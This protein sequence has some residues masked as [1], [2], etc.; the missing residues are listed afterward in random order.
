MS[1]HWSL[2]D[3]AIDWTIE[4]ISGYKWSSVSQTGQQ[5][6][7]IWRGF[8]QGG[9]MHPSAIHRDRPFSHQH[10][11]QPFA[12]IQVEFICCTR[13]RSFKQPEWSIIIIILSCSSSRDISRVFTSTFRTAFIFGFVHVSAMCVGWAL[14]H[15]AVDES[16][17]TD[18]CGTLIDRPCFIFVVDLLIVMALIGICRRRKA[19]LIDGSERSFHLLTYSLCNW[20]DRSIGQACSDHLSDRLEWSNSPRNSSTGTW[21]TRSALESDSR[22]MRDSSSALGLG[23]QRSNGYPMDTSSKHWSRQ[24]YRIR[25]NSRATLGL[26]RNRSAMNDEVE[27]REQASLRSLGP[28]VLLRHVQ[29]WSIRIDN[30]RDRERERGG[31]SQ[32]LLVDTRYEHWRPWLDSLRWFPGRIRDVHRKQCLTVG[33]LEKARFMFFVK[34]RS[35]VTV[36]LGVPVELVVTGNSSMS[37]FT[38]GSVLFLDQQ[39][40]KFD[41]SYDRQTS[42]MD[43]TTLLLTFDTDARL[44]HRHFHACISIT[45]EPVVA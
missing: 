41:T 30:S 42:V 27:A 9:T 29:I 33:C 36:V 25:S 14:N 4:S 13:K 18:T 1:G 23:D 15:R 8:S 3:W 22:A 39:A 7:A 12:S 45:E 43:R 44:W 26:E 16:A 20:I 24:F 31:E 10:R 11:M 17:L 38:D 19:A 2:E 32:L 21:N 35:V 28:R 37:T 5:T 34:D 6:L 40:L